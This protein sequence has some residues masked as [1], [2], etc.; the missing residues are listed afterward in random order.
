VSLDPQELIRYAR[1]LSL[2]E[3]G[4][5]GQE[6]LKSA[7]V[8]IVG[9]GGLGSP[10]A[11]YLAAAGVGT[12]GLVDF[13]HVDQTNLHRQILHGTGAVGRP[14]LESA[15]RRLADLNPMVRL[16]PIETRLTSAN[17]LEVIR[18]FDFTLD[19]SDNFPTRYLVNDASVL[20]GK[21]YVYGSIFRFDGQVS[22]FGARGGPCYRCLFA[23]PPEPELI[24]SCAQAGVLG[25]LP[26]VIGTLQAME[27]IKLILSIGEPLVG[28]L[29]LYDG[30][31]A[32]FREVIVRPDPACPAC[33]DHRTITHLIDYDAFC[34]LRPAPVG[35]RSG[36]LEPE[37]VVA[38]R[39]TGRPIE[40]IDVREEWEWD[41]ARIEGTKHIPLAELPDRLAELDP[42]A[43]V[44]AICHRGTR[45]RLARDLLKGAGFQARNLA[46]GIDAWAERVDPSIAR[47]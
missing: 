43:E 46:G 31:K 21:P 28:R 35:A 38:L 2:P 4:T 34:G 30:L 24:P 18:R 20:A 11:L 37:D 22:V 15:A 45:S 13:D 26:G 14:K 39:Q 19:G 12:I 47:Y 3:V 25:V 29:L 7:R 32:R 10:A 27:A 33:G 44:V 40:L 9:A 23:E 16:E 36:E 1:H 6:A 8:L 42:K 17:A 41:L 5:R